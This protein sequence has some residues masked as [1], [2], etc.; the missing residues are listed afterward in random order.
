MGL[1]VGPSLKGGRW[2][3]PQEVLGA[4][5]VSVFVQFLDGF[6]LQAVTTLNKVVRAAVQ[7]EE[8]IYTM[9]NPR[10]IHGSGM[11]TLSN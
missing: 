2:V 5:S 11:K 8:H 9:D 1:G 4:I 10:F 6:T 3:A 7:Q